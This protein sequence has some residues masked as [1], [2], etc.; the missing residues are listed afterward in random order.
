MKHLKRLG[1]ALA[2][3]FSAAVGISTIAAN[4][5]VFLPPPP[6]ATLTVPACLFPLQGAGEV[7][8]HSP[9]FDPQDELVRSQRP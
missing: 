5:S 9:K 4:L 8:L 3:S 6:S 1:M 2:V 7:R